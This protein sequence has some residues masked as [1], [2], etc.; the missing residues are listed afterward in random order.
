MDQAKRPQRREKAPTLLLTCEHAGNEIPSAYKDLFAKSRGVLETH[1]GWDPGAFEI[2]NELQKLSGA[3]LYFTKLSRLIVDM[4]RSSRSSSLLSKWTSGLP[5]AQRARILERFYFPYRS[6]IETAVSKELKK[7][8]VAHLGIHS[9]SPY[10]DPARRSCQIG[11]LFDPKNRFEVEIAQHLRDRL[12]VVFPR[13]EIRMNF[14]YRGDDDGLTTDLRKK[15]RSSR[16][17]KRYAGIEIEFNQAFLR[18]LQKQKSTR[19][20]SRLFYFALESA[21]S[22]SPEASPS[23]SRFSADQLLRP[24]IRR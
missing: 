18:K 22:N 9:F 11:I 5:P 20:F 14:P 6:T 13:L 3:P 23:R 8:S 2:A 10:L 16:I 12:E 24:R 1:R 17:S 21:L 7:N 15:I 4:N 19:S